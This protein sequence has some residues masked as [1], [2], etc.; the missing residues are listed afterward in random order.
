ML[1]LELALAR[2]DFILDMMDFNS[3]STFDFFVVARHIFW[4][5][6]KRGLDSSHDLILCTLVSYDYVQ[7]EIFCMSQL[8]QGMAHCQGSCLIELLLA[9]HAAVNGKTIGLPHVCHTHLHAILN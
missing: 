4:Y 8:H 7:I 9:V 6:H 3:D 2:S 5:S 1:C